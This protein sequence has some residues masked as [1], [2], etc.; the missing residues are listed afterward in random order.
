MQTA[1]QAVAD[2][3]KAGHADTPG[4]GFSLTILGGFL[5]MP[6]TLLKL[7]LLWPKERL[8]YDDFSVKIIFR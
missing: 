4:F 8:F 7:T 5:M 2:D 6:E 3:R 1:R